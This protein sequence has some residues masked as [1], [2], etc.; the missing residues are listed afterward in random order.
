[1]NLL[2]TLNVGLLPS[3]TITS[4]RLSQDKR[5]LEAMRWAFTFLEPGVYVERARGSEPTLVL[6]G[7]YKRGHVALHRDVGTLASLCEQDCVA[8]QVT[9]SAAQHRA[10]PGQL[11]GPRAEA[12][13]PFDPALFIHP[14]RRFL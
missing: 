3:E 2:V 5:E 8:Y 11:A 7:V 6:H 4:P 13:R 9:A 12:W 14:T 10:Y 1:M